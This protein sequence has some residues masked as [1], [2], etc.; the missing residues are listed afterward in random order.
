M[1]SLER[2]HRQLG[3]RGLVVLGV[4]V[5]ADAAAY[6]KFLRELGI[7]FMN[8]H[9]PDRK[10]SALYGTFMYP[11]TYII[12]AQGRLVRKIIGAMEW[13]EPQIVG[14]LETLLGQAGQAA[15]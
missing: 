14:Q 10:I 15:R 12:D 7:T 4:S 3:P 11:E 5:D 6:E 13:D 9:D 2:L 8:H 1:P